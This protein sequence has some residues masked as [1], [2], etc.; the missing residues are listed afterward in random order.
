MLFVLAGCGASGQPGAST[1]GGAPGKKA[2][3]TAGMVSDK[4]GIG[5]LSFNWMAWEGL[6]RAQKDLGVEVVKIESQQDADYQPNLQ[7]LAERG[8]KVVFAV[9]FAL[10]PAVKEV[11]PKYPDTHF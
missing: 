10:E 6:Q 3:F 4:G 8:C 2:P 7:R 5:D 1:T 11:A 9:G